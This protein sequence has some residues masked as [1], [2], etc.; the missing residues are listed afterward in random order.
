M[1]QMRFA[2]GFSIHDAFEEE[3]TETIKVYGNGN[4]SPQSA[5]NQQN[6]VNN[7]TDPENV[8]LRME[9]SSFDHR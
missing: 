1:S 6:G 8:T 7:Q 4:A 2:N 9:S 5:L 3:E